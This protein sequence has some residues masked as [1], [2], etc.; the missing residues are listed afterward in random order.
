MWPVRPLA[1]CSRCDCSRRASA[2]GLPAAAPRLRSRRR[3]LH[4]PRPMAGCCTSL[5]CAC[6]RA[7]LQL[8]LPRCCREQSAAALL[9]CRPNCG[10]ARPC[11]HR[12]PRCAPPAARALYTSTWRATFRRRRCGRRHAVP[13]RPEAARVLR[14]PLAQE[15]KGAPAA[16]LWP[17]RHSWRTFHSCTRASAQ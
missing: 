11:S 5:T 3:V 1:P 4:H 9:L 13:R 7:A 2:A 16:R 8:Q 14:R 10:R 12:V 17:R 6:G 15:K